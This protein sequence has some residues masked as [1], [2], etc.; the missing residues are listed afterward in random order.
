[1]IQNDK[2]VEKCPVYGCR[3]KIEVL[4]IMGLKQ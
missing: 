4:K 3:G 2:G 1:M